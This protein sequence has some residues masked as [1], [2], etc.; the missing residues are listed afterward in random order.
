MKAE[1]ASDRAKAQGRRRLL[2]LLGGLGILG[3]VR[4]AA[5]RPVQ[6][7]QAPQALSVKEADFY[8]THDL[9]G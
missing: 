9:A 8:R 7:P 2:A 5:S 4:P 3:L 6:G 1:S